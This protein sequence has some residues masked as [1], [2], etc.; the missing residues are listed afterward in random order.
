MR[1]GIVGLFGSNV[2][3]VECALDTYTTSRTEGSE[4]YR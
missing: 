4:V 1:K 2:L 3:V